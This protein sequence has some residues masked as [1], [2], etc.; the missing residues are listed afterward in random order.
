[1]SLRKIFLALCLIITFVFALALAA[2][3]EEVRVFDKNDMLSA[4]DEVRITEAALAAEA[5]YKCRFYIVTHEAD[6]RFDKY[7]GEDFIKEHGFSYNDDILLLIITYDIYERTYY[8]NMYYYGMPSRRISD[9][10]VNSILDSTRVY[11]KLKTGQLADGAIA[12]IELAGEASKMP[13]ILLIVIAVIFAGIV[14]GITVSTITAKYKMKRNPTN[15]PLD[16]YAKLKLT[17]S[18]DKFLD[19][20]VSV[21]LTSSGGD[22]GG[23]GVGGGGGY[24]GGRGHAGGR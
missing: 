16:K 17:S 9:S 19:K 8:Y 24:G 14:C 2:S 7:I 20:H 6:G 13:W 22:S 12:F 21:I 11:N 1:M 4:A 10:E 15:Y 3:A 18:D 5:Q 23:R